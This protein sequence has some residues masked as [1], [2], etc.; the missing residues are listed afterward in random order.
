MSGELRWALLIAMLAVSVGVIAGTLLLPPL[1]PQAAVSV[2][3]PRSIPV[4]E[5][6][7]DDTHTAAA[8]PE[9]ST[10]VTVQL[11]GPGGLITASACGPGHIVQT[12]EQL[13][14]VDGA[15]R[16][17]IVTD[18]PLWR[19]LGPGDDGADVASLQRLLKVETSGT[20]D[21]AT[22]SA[23]RALQETAQ[24]E[25][26]G[27]ITLDAVQ[28]VPAGIGAVAS[29]EISIGTSVETAGT[30]LV[31]G[32]ALVALEF[33][34]DPT[35][36]PG[37]GYAAAVGEL[38]VPL[39]PERRVTDPELLAAIAASSGY[40]QWMKDPG[41]G[42]PVELRLVEP[43]A[44]VGIPPSAVFL[45]GSARGCVLTVD[46]EVVPVEILASELGTVFAVPMSAVSEVLAPIN[47][48][49]QECE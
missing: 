33:P 22:S 14:A 10:E 49:V 4:A 44:A 1:I 21:R 5:R 7:F 8:T 23:V 31:A 34:D 43:I 20:F 41:A 27:R 36:I 17:A 40:A 28:W 9:L 18:V 15:A 38:T 25:A 47:E 13:F 32:G 35:E 48:E 12:G 2:E 29:C 30:V 3:G 24:V 11:S 6:V 16:I 39:D 19:D 37:Q 26:T 45:T 46:R 42:V